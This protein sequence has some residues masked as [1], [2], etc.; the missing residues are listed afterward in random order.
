MSLEPWTINLELKQSNTVRN[1]ENRKRRQLNRSIL[2]LSHCGRSM[3]VGNENDKNNSNGNDN[4]S[5]V[6]NKS[7]PITHKSGTKA[8]W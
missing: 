5:T 7:I 2:S 4:W 1:G 8:E 3:K 6:S